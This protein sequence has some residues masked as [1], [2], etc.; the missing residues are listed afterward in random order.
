MLLQ[1]KQRNIQLRLKAG[2]AFMRALDDPASFSASGGKQIDEIFVPEDDNALMRLLA[3]IEEQGG[4]TLEQKLYKYGD[5]SHYISQSQYEG[6]LKQHKT[7]A[8]DYLPLNRIA[9]YTFMTTKVK[10]QKITTL[11]QRVYDRGQMREKIEKDSM[12]LISKYF[13]QRG[14]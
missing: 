1:E 5:P 10:K 2:Q 8:S 3:K 6:M 11:L 14:Y 7:D 9:G 4:A 12:Q 13:F